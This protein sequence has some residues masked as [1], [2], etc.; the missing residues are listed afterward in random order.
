MGNNKFY[1]DDRAPFKERA[2]LL[3]GEER[4]VILDGYNNMN[5]KN[6]MIVLGIIWALIFV[7]SVSFG[8][9]K[10][11]ICFIGATIFLCYFLIAHLITLRRVVKKVKANKMYAID[12]VYDDTSG[13]YHR[14][15]LKN[16]KKSY[17]GYNLLVRESLRKGDKV[18]VLQMLG[19]AWVYKARN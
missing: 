16:Y 2:R 18:V 5:L 10:G 15:Y 13:K 12:A 7:I 11:E 14:V 4:K 19:Q 6:V 3:T 17:G 1:K 9:K 8:G